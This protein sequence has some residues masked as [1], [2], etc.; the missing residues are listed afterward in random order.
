MKKEKSSAWL[1]AASVIILFALIQ[2]S[3]YTFGILMPDMVADTG[4]TETQ[5]LVMSTFNTGGTFVMSMFVGRVIPKTKAKGAFLIG[6]ILIPLHFVLYYLSKSL[7]TIYIAAAISGIGAA[8]IMTAAPVLLSNWFVAKRSTVITIAF[9]SMNVG[10]AIFMYMA[11]QTVASMGWRNVE[12]LNAGIVLVLS[13]L[14]SIF[15]LREKP[16]DVGQKPY[17]YDQVP[18]TAEAEVDT[19]K[20]LTVKE[21][22]KSPS[23]Y[24]LFI[25]FFAVVTVAYCY[26][27]L[28]PTYLTGIGM[29][30]ESASAYVSGYSIV[31][32]VAS[33]I[34]GM[35]ADKWG[36]KVYLIYCGVAALAGMFLL[37]CGT[38]AG[39]VI[40]I[41]VLLTG[42]GD[43]IASSSAS[44]VTGKCFGMKSYEKLLGY[45]QGAMTFGA[46]VMLLVVSALSESIG[47]GMALKAAGLFTILGVVLILVAMRLSPA[48][49]DS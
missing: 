32:I 1:I 19:S 11:G 17:G 47:M 30:I 29:S 27:S 5:I 28:V 37:T 22:I 41:S 18:E 16:E 3:M 6:G 9:G 36:E 48:R 25:G 43:P 2:G 13:L 38:M 21:A 26:T 45:M 12:L 44:L 15:V 4:Y 23:F 14:I 49:K 40:A 7:L 39:I 34:A 10:G 20:G 24:I 35:V 8:L 42:L 33:V 31:A 46:T